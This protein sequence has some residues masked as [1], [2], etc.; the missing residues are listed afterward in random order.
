MNTTEAIDLD[1]MRHSGSILRET[2][3][4]LSTTFIVPGI[5]TLDIS[6]KATEIICSYEGATPSFLGY[7][8]FPAATCISV[9]EQVVHGIPL[10]NKIIKDG[11]LVSVDCGVS[12]KGHFTDACRTVGVG[13]VDYRAKKLIKITSEALDRGI[14]AA[15][16]GGYVGDISFAVQMHVERNRFAVSL[17]LVGHGIGRD[18]HLPPSIPNYGPPGQGERLEDGACLAIEPVVFDGPSKVVVQED[19]W[20]IV[21][22]QGNLS[23]HFEDTII[24]TR[25]GPEIITR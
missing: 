7:L 10:G 6:N 5:S 2:L 3:E 13:N 1:L 11:D 22:E 20:T 19:A 16:V 4:F 15:L 18:L 8:G 9:N 21:S 12:Y 17:D 24:L 25:A 23:A 14:A